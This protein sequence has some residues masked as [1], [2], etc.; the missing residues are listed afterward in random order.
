MQI[1]ALRSAHDAGVQVPARTIKKALEIVNT[2]QVTPSENKS[3]DHMWGYAYSPKQK[4]ARP[5]T[6]AAGILSLQIA[7]DYKNK[8]MKK[9]LDRLLYLTKKGHREIRKHSPAYFV[10]YASM[11]FYQAGGKYWKEG[12]PLIKDYILK[13]QGRRLGKSSRPLEAAFYLLALTVPYRYLPIYQ[14]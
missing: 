7:G 1:L 5:G 2:A 4:V 3:L 11:A 12:Y 8:K 9:A 6:T 13:T 10:Y 14:N